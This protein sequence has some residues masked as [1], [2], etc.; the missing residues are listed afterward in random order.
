MAYFDRRAVQLDLAR[1]IETVPAVLRFFDK[2]H[3]AGMNMVFLYLEDRIKTKTYPYADD[4]ESYTPDQIREMVAY[5]E[6]LGLELVPVVSPVG[7]TGRFLKHEELKHIAELRGKIAGAY[8]E[9]GVERYMATCPQLPAT[10]EFFDAYLKEVAELFPSPFFH[11]GFDEIWDM[12]FCELCKHKSIADLYYEAVTHF[13]DVLKACGKDCMIWDDMLEQFPWVLEKLP[14]DIIPCAW[15]YQ[16]TERYPV[17]RFSTERSYDLFGRFEQLGFRY[18]ACCWR[19]NS[20]DSLTACAAKSHPFGMLMTNWEMSDERT[21]PY[22]YTQLYQAGALWRDGAPVGHQTLT[23]AAARF[24]DTP[25][26]AEAIAM[27]FSNQWGEAGYR[28]P[29]EKAAYYV[30]DESAYTDRAIVNAVRRILSTATGDEDVLDSLRVLIERKYVTMHLWEIGYALHEYRSGEGVYDIEY[31]RREAAAC[32]REVETLR[33]MAYHVWDHNRPGLAHPAL[34]ATLDGLAK[35]AAY[36]VSASATATDHD[37]GRLVVRFDLSSFCS[38]CTTTIT[39]GYADG[40]TYQA[41]RGNYKAV[42]VR[43]IVKYDYSFTIPADKEPTSI[44]VMIKG[45]GAAGV[46]YASATMPGG[47][48]FLPV[49]LTDVH[50]QIDHPE[51]LLYDDS[52]PAVFGEPEMQQF[53]VNHITR[54]HE[55]TVTLALG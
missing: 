11:I 33:E 17:A 18:F 40:S 1:Q 9:A 48:H 50:G 30:P 2:A 32:A 42:H 23:E 35:S 41:A 4:A 31:L 53:F 8:N 7:H 20:V 14:R 38:S 46:R 44:T 36:L 10:H 54:H 19:N 16:F 34:D 25:A 24:T 26:A 28:I 15:F 3:D 21:L 55:N 22:L 6:K 49:G 13:H 47:R 12:G 27:I 39:V 37:H 5:A 43:S 29:G 52:R 51:V 45:Y